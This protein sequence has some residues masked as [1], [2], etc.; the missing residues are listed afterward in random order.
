MI[1][2][3]RT[4]CFIIPGYVKFK[5]V[6]LKDLLQLAFFT[7][8]G[9]ANDPATKNSTLLGSG[10][11]LRLVVDKYVVGRIDFA[12]PLGDAPTDGRDGKLRVHFSLALKF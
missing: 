1:T 11:G 9:W 6:K 3:L 10:L 12:W 8:M 5:T 7:D 2:E 4:P